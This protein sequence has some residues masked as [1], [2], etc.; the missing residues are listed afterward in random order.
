MRNYGRGTTGRKCR[1]GNDN[2]QG[3]HF[4]ARV[5]VEVEDVHKACIT[6]LCKSIVNKSSAH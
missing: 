5:E 2:I 6:I 1:N 4:E 3:I